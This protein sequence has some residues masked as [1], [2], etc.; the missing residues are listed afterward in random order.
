[1]SHKADCLCNCHDRKESPDGGPVFGP[2]HATNKECQRALVEEAHDLG[3]REREQ[4]MMRAYHVTLDG[5]NAPPNEWPCIRVKALVD[6]LRSA[7]FEE[8]AIAGKGGR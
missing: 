6:S 1:M 2:E 3:R 4:E 5:L 8:P 7:S